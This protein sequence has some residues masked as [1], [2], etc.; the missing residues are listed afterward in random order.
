MYNDPA[1]IVF[2]TLAHG[3]AGFHHKNEIAREPNEKLLLQMC[4]MNQPRKSKTAEMNSVTSAGHAAPI[5]CAIRS[6]FLP[7]LVLA[8]TTTASLAQ[9]VL[10]P[11][12]GLNAAIREALQK[13]GGALTEPDM[14]TLTN[15]DLNAHLFARRFYRVLPQKPVRREGVHPA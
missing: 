13:P 4:S 14:L 15:L 12:P 8:G 6:L 10:V 11:D 9:E 5:I 2:A 7:L 3:G 1:T